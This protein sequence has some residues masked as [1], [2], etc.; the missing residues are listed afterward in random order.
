MDFREV[1]AVLHGSILQSHSI[2]LANSRVELAPKD[3][4]SVRFESL[5]ILKW[6][7]TGS[8]TSAMRVAVVGLERLGAGEPWRL[9]LK[10]ENT[11][12]LELTCARVLCEGAEVTGIGRSYRH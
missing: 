4:P 8:P 12:E 11:G 2:D 10:S 1:T 6:S 5:T 7:G 9:Y 3:A